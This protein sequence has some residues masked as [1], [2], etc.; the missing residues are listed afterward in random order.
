[1]ARMTKM[2]GQ[3]SER[4][5]TS[6]VVTLK[7]SAISEEIG[8]KVNHSSCEIRATN[9]KTSKTTQRY[10]DACSMEL[11]SFIGSFLCELSVNGI[12]L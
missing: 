3:T 11:V 9:M 1:M 5:E 2:T 8:A 6:F 10:E 7:S 12:I 4:R